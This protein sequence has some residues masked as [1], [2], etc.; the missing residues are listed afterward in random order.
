MKPGDLVM[1]D[2]P[3]S[4]RI[5]NL[6]HIHGMPGFIIERDPMILFDIQWRI[7]VD[8]CVKTLSESH[9]RRLDETG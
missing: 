4:I 9:F 2:L 8:G 1:I 6:A 3:R 5:G 7:F